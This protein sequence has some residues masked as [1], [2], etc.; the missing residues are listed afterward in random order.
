M[1]AIAAQGSR[2]LLDGA[3]KVG[4]GWERRVDMRRGKVWEEIMLSIVVH[5]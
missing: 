4:V 5:D 3:R 1:A 2:G